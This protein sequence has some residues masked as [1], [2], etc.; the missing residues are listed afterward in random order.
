[1]IHVTRKARL[2]LAVKLLLATMK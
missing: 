1:M 2:G